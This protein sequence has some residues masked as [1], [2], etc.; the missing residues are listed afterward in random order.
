MKKTLFSTVVLLVTIFSF[1]KERPAYVAY[2]TGVNIRKTASL[3]ADLLGKIPYAT[4]LS[5][6]L[7]KKD[8]TPVFV[9]G[10][11][12]Y[13]VPVSFQNKKGYVLDCYLTNIVPPK[14]GTKTMEE[15][16]SQL[17]PKFGAPLLYK[18]PEPIGFYE[19]GYEIKKQ[20]YKNGNEI[21]EIKGYESFGSTYFFVQMESLQE[22]FLVMRQI[23]EF[24]L[25]FSEKDEFP[26]QT[27]T[28]TKKSDISNTVEL[29]FTIDKTS[30]GKI[31]WIK[32][33][34]LEYQEGASYELEIFY[35]D[36]HIVI[37]Y[38]GGV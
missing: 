29:K 13:W 30:W 27:K 1:A 22:A 8:S 28:I 16:I 23:E 21:H 14:K 10:M 5:I 17:S 6:D 18:S 33:I 15:Y 12:G 24:Q 20:F 4:K 37:S 32:K 25:F 34:V 2:S 9:E 3:N 38:G 31:D 19:N 35:L 11:T 36:G 7:S 26:N